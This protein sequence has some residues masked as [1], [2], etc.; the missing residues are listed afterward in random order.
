MASYNEEWDTFVFKVRLS[1]ALMIS[2]IELIDPK[3]QDRHFHVPK[4]KLINQKIYTGKANPFLAIFSKSDIGV[5]ETN[6]YNLDDGTTGS[7]FQSLLSLL[8]PRYALPNA[9]LLDQ[10]SDYSYVLYQW[11]FSRII[12]EE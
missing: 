12:I 2:D 7:D 5:S 1:L 4:A 9:F 3:V 10:H 8:Y 6:A 11:C